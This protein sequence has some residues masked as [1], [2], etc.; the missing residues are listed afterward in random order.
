M[1]QFGVAREILNPLHQLFKILSKKT[2]KN[3]AIFI[4]I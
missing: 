1:R 4:N 3:T 2:K